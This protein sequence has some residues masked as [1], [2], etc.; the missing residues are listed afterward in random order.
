MSEEQ[1]KLDEAIVPVDAAEG[2]PYIR[3]KE[4][5]PLFD[6]ILDNGVMLTIVFDCC[7]S[8]SLS[9]GQPENV[10]PKCRYLPMDT[11]DI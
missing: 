9:R 11:V 7:H 5:A 8:G 4:L 3:D 2:A 10:L 1:D 6:R